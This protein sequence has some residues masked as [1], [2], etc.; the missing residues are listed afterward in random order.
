MSD[1]DDSP[2]LGR[3]IARARVRAGLTQRELAEQAGYRPKSGSVT[4]SRI[5]NDVIKPSPDKLAALARATNT[6]DDELL[7]DAGMT[8]GV[9]GRV[10]KG[11]RRTTTAAVAGSQANRNEERRQ[12][13][14]D[15]VAMLEDNTGEAMKALSKASDQ[16]R[17][18]FM[19]TFLELASKVS[20]IEEPAPSADGVPLEPSIGRRFESQREL[21]R[22]QIIQAARSMAAGGGVGAVAGAGAAYAAFAATAAWATASTGTAIAGLSGAAATSATFAALGGGSLAAGGLGVAGGT[23]LLTGIV[24]L[25]ALIAIGAVV[26]KKRSRFKEQAD[27]DATRLAEANTHIQGMWDNFEQFWEWARRTEEIFDAIVKQSSKPL[28]LFE[29]AIQRHSTAL[30]AGELI[31]F[32]DLDDRDRQH[33]EQLLQL[34]T[35]MVSVQS[36]PLTALLGSDVADD[37]QRDTIIEWNELVLS[38]SEST[39]GIE[40]TQG[41]AKAAIPT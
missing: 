6:T 36:L 15:E 40:T 1:T 24:A 10:G 17:D 28:V 39:L 31:P 30:T 19:L 7:R 12:Q 3:A 14:I 9:I 26:A 5:E 11:L 33:V 16:A 29:D 25:P 21:L 22:E 32:D 37:T 38:E 35:T 8:P 27:E 23:A 34:A 2:T 41:K 13:I 4:V 20:G 18:D